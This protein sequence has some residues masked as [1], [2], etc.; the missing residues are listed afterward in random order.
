MTDYQ[1]IID[2]MCWNVY[3]GE[4]PEQA[5]TREARNNTPP[6]NEVIDIVFAGGLQKWAESLEVN[7]ERALYNR[8]IFAMRKTVSDPIFNDRARVNNFPPFANFFYYCQKLD[9][10][11]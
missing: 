7:S 6:P 3:E 10:N 8:I 2:V 4:T 5:F 9:R 1:K 11:G